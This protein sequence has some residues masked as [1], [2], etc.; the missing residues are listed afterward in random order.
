MNKKTAKK[1]GLQYG[2]RLDI[3]FRDALKTV[4]PCS[5]RDTATYPVFSLYWSLAR[6][7]AQIEHQIQLRAQWVE[8][9]GE[10][11]VNQVI[12][13]AKTASTEVVYL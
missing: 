8:K 3:G 5:G 12:G 7:K 6:E 1:L 9:Y 2:A 4:G 13:L 11:L 10:E